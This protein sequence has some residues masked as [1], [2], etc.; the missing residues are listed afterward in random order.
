MTKIEWFNDLTIGMRF[1]IGEVQIT[2]VACRCREKSWPAG[3]EGSA[4]L[5]R[6]EL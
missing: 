4:A 1:K 5:V 6:D 2:D 3:T